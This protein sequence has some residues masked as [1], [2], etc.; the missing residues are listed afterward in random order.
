MGLKT[1]L[2]VFKTKDYSKPEPIK[3]LYGGGKKQSE[4][5]I[6]KSIRNLFKI[7]KKK[8]QLKIE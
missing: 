5:N 6:S 7:K 3:S 2:W 8:K 4:G 1:N